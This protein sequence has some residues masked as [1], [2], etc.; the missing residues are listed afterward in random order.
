MSIY[1]NTKEKRQL[2]DIFFDTDFTDYTDYILIR[3]AAKGILK[4]YLGVLRAFPVGYP[5]RYDRGSPG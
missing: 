5:L 1:T 3:L 4:S 2:V